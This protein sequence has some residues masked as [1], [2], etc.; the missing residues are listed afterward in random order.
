[1]GKKE[2]LENWE[3]DS[4]VKWA[5]DKRR[6]RGTGRWQRKCDGANSCQRWSYLRGGRGIDRG[7]KDGRPK[8]TSVFL[9]GYLCWELARKQGWFRA[10]LDGTQH[11]LPTEEKLSERRRTTVHR[12]RSWT[13]T[14][15]RRY[16]VYITYMCR[17][18]AISPIWFC[19]S[20]LDLKLDNHPV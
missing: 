3:I 9:L 1:M 6:E 7:L 11:H 13:H 16:I 14:N 17:N 18:A 2:R 20:S 4:K 19:S 12:W 10:H 8:V 5:R 15:T